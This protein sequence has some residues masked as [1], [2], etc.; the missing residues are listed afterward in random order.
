MSKILDI[1]RQ[2]ARLDA[3]KLSELAKIFLKDFCTGSTDMV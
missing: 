2:N 3:T 1:V